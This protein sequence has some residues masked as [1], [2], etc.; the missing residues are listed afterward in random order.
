VSALVPELQLLLHSQNN[1]INVS[2]RRDDYLSAWFVTDEAGFGRQDV[3]PEVAGY[4]AHPIFLMPA[5]ERRWQINFKVPPGLEAGWQPVRVRTARSPFSNEILIPVDV[6]AVADSLFIRG[7]CDGMDWNPS[8][9]SMGHGVVSLWV[10]GLP[11]NADL[12]N[13]AIYLGD[14][15]LAPEFIAAEPDDKDSRQ[16]N[17]RLPRTIEPGPGD[18]VV[19]IGEVESNRVPFSV[20]E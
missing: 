5:G 19:R 6:P 13:V 9:V 1:G 18:L 12:H 7:A 20:A 11:A 4:G 10:R 2:S 17:A 14:A 8:S 16:V 15:R 3:F